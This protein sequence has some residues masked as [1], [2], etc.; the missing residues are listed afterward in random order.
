M[1]RRDR[2]KQVVDTQLRLFADTHAGLLHECDVA[3][4]AYDGAPRDEAEDRYAAYQDHV[5]DVA[6]ALAG[7][8]DAYAATLAE[9]DAEAY[10][11]SFHRAVGRHLPA[12]AAEV[13]RS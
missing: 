2:F 7:M 5:E 13:E 8:R 1:F 3:L 12:F 4:R 11:A 6:E 10:E 9:E